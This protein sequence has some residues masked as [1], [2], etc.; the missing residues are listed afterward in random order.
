MIFVCFILVAALCL[1]LA[2]NSLETF[3]AENYPIIESQEP[4]PIADEFYAEK[5][6]RQTNQHL[7]LNESSKKIDE[8]NP[9]QRF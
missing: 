2:K 6:P 3:E 5:E 8:G 4:Q 7:E 1:V 9:V